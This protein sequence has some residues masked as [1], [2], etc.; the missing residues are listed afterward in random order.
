MDG[1]RGDRPSAVMAGHV[2][3]ERLGEDML[4]VD[5]GGQGTARR[6]LTQYLNHV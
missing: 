1:A 4:E 5:L 2:D 3:L 6:K